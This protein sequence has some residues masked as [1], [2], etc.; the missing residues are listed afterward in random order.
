MFRGKLVAR[1]VAVAAAAVLAAGAA[2]TTASARPGAG[3]I[4]YGYPNNSHGVWC[5]QHLINDVAQDHGI[6]RPLQED[7]AF[8]KHTYDW[9]RWFQTTY[10]YHADGI[11][12]PDTGGAL[13][14]KGDAYYGRTNYCYN[15][16]P[17]YD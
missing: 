16:L 6:H 17:T 2:A 12:G 4:G 1:A 14:A 10:Y 15:Y 3:Y 11:V 9:I 8:G 5:V 7:G 13:L